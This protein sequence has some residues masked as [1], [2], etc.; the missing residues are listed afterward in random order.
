MPTLADFSAPIPI[1]QY[2]NRPGVYI[3][4]G[5]DNKLLYIGSS[6]QL[7]R[8]VS[9]LTAL[10]RDTTNKVGFTHVKARLMR[11]YLEK[12]H[13]IRIRFLEC[14][15]YKSVEKQLIANYKTS[16]NK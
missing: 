11:D 1:P 16:W 5:E 4:I 10:Q 9:H 7:C 8:R 14:K 2:P 3:I 6:K 13:K 15:N 12:G